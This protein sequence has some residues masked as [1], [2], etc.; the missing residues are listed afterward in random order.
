M[1]RQL[2]Q[3]IAFIFLFIVTLGTFHNPFVDDYL[4]DL[5][6]KTVTVANAEDPLY[7]KIE[8]AALN[9]NE[10][11]VD[12]I[13]H[14]V[15]KA[16]PGYNGFKVDVEASYRKMKEKDVFSK[17]KLVFK[18][19]SPDVHLDDLPPAPV[20][21][22]NP[23]KPMVSLMINVAWGNEYI[24]QMLKVMDDMNVRA[25]FFLDGS[26]TKKHP[27]MAK[28]IAEEGHQIGNH[29]YSHPDLNKM[30]AP[31]AKQELTKT[32]TVIHAIL[33]IKPKFFAPPSGSLNDETVTIAD[34]LG[35]KTILWSVDSVDW[36]KPH[37]Q[38]MVQKV[39]TE[40]HA[41]ALILM[42]PTQPAE[43]GM[44]DLIRGIRERGYR[45]GTVSELLS[46]NRA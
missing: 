6:A 33:G 1:N 42:H 23:K 36:K 7:K 5:K 19:V 12:A 44:A 9:Q 43:E 39:L 45:I 40:V 30:G 37:P 3:W 25:T 38:D 8:Q 21:K 15:W 28:M 41:G 22:G 24:P 27:K 4:S 26:W 16:I 17:E 13:I 29:A 35:M 14:R 34:S 32:N 46:E 10:P 18:E 20:Y 2:L 31:A 11:A